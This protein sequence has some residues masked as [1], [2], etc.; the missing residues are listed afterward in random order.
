L[1]LACLLWACFAVDR[2]LYPRFRAEGWL[3]MRLAL[4]LFASISCLLGA[5]MGYQGIA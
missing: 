2:A 4:T 5:W 3:P 1:V